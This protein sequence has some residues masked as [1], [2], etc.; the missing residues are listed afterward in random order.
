MFLLKRSAGSTPAPGT[1]EIAR[2]AQDTSLRAYV[3]WSAMMVA[4]VTV[5]GLLAARLIHWL[6]LD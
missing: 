1:H 4:I 2:P 5:V 6:G 3:K